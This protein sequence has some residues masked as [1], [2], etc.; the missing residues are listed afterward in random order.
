[1]FFF[2]TIETKWMSEWDVYLLLGALKKVL[3]FLE[4]VALKDYE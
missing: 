1:M 3:I 4:P 2:N